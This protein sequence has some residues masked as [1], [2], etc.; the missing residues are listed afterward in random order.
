[1]ENNELKHYGVL[2]MKWGIRRTEAQL[3]RATKRVERLKA[4]KKKLDKLTRAKNKLNKMMEE[5]E[6]LKTSLKKPKKDKPEKEPKPEKV[7]PEKKHKKLSE[8]SDEELNA[9]INRIRM[10]QTYR[11]MTADKTKKAKLFNGQNFVN[12]LSEQVVT[13]LGVQTVKYF[14]AKAINK[15]LKEEGVYTNN[16]KK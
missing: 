16:K 14:G 7:K 9:R 15:L 6:K 1:M 11:E 2:G 10:E 8:M 12:K 3:G 13:D 4:K 5:E